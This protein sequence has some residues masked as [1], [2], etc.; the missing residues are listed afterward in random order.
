MSVHRDLGV[1][2]GLEAIAVHG[3]AV[4]VSAHAFLEPDRTSFDR[5]LAN[6][7][8]GVYTYAPREGRWLPPHS[9]SAHADASAQSGGA[10]RQWRPR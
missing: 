1:L 8:G 9:Q 3:D 4:R 7:P 2:H 6:A 10:E 5:P